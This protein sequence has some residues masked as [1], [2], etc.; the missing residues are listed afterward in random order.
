[1]A[2]WMNREAGLKDRDKKEG[3][4]FTAQGLLAK[5]K[6]LH[7]RMTRSKQATVFS[8]YPTAKIFEDHQTEFEQQKSRAIT[9]IPRPQTFLK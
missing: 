9:H 5:A 8:G 1:M 4:P 3:T 7:R 2:G 6:N